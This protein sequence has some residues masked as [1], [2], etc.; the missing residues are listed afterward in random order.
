[1]NTS[2]EINW[3]FQ[4]VEL[5]VSYGRDG[6]ATVKEYREDLGRHTYTKKNC[7]AEYTLSNEQARKVREAFFDHINRR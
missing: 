4:G 3:D 6:L 7:C 5:V 1:M 2:S